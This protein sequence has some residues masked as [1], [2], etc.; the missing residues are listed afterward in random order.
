MI[1]MLF[2]LLALS[3]GGDQKDQPDAVQCIVDNIRDLEDARDPK[4]HATAT[5]LINFMY[6]TPLT[7]TARFR[8]NELQKDFIRTIWRKAGK[9]PVNAAALA[10]PIAAALRFKETGDGGTKITLADG[11]SVT[12]TE[13]DRRQY[14]SVAYGLRAQL[15][16]QQEAMLSAEGPLPVLTRDGSDALKEAVD[17]HTLTT[18]FLADQEARTKS[19][20]EV[21]EDLFQKS[22]QRV[23]QP[24]ETVKPV[25]VTARVNAAEAGYPVLSRIIEQKI[26]SYREYNKI[27]DMLFWSNIS[28]FFARHALPEDEAGRT[29]LRQNFRGAAGYFGAFLLRESGRIAQKDGSPII[30][31]R[32]VNE[33]LQKLTPFKVDDY[34]DITYFYH[35]PPKERY[36]L[37][38]Y[39]TDAFRDSGLHWIVL[40]DA[41]KNPQIRVPVEPDPFAAELIV[42]GIAQF[43]VLVFRIAGQMSKNADAETV[44][45]H[46]IRAAVNLIRQLGAKHASTPAPNEQTQTLV[47]TTTATPTGEEPFFTDITAAS[48]LSFVHRS[49]DWLRRYMRSYLYSVENK[50]EQEDISLD[51]PPS[52]SGSGVAAEDIDGDGLPDILLLS[53]LGDRLYKNLG[54]GRFQDITEQAGLVWS[55]PDGSRGEPRQ[56]IIADLDNDGLRDILI[57][58]VDD[59]HRLYKNMGGN[60]FK[61]VTKTAG[62]GGKGMVAGPATVFDYDRDGLPD[63]YIG[64]YGNYLEGVGPS[65]VRNNYNG[66][67]NRLFRNKGNLQFE[68]KTEGSGLD[69]KGWT[70]AV[71]HTDIDGDGLQDLIVGND[72]GINAYY[73]N[74]GDG[75]FVDIAESL[76]TNLPS[77]S[78]NVGLADLNRDSYPDVYISNIVTM[79]KDESYRLPTRETRM[80]FNPENMATMRILEA[81]HLFVSKRENNKLAGY[82]IS[83]A[84]T[85]GLI[86]TGWAWDADFL[87]FDN[88]GD[89]DLYCVNGLNEYRFYT[90]SVEME[91]QDGGKQTFMWMVRN[92]ESNVFFVNEG[93]KLENRSTESGADLLGNSRSAAYLDIEGDGDLDMILN[94]YHGPAVLYRNNAERYKRNWL[95]LQLDGDPAKGSNRDAIGARI[96]ITPKGGPV[97]WR[98]ISGSIGYLSQHPKE[99]HAGLA[100]ATE[101]DVTIIWPNGDTTEHK[102][103]AAGKTWR[104]EQ[105][106]SVKLAAN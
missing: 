13:R 11:S 23:A 104:I 18:L 56:P 83:D 51:H 35:L 38:A 74:K 52:F 58:Y 43:G 96:L 7:E 12:I 25:E 95:R 17:L 88:D 1:A 46:H 48:G 5:R 6:G 91:T 21:S 37:E 100:D 29:D 24:L 3:L 90:D 32:H 30:R 92:K 45:G 75:T 39:D 101:A 86:S 22:W 60:K 28:T 8:M 27:S 4:C 15:A 40:Q 84:I 16:V 2:T 80:K 50:R 81:N 47:S 31:E 69:N 33:A 97:V 85:R 9:G 49:S 53:G 71:S 99:V 102:G 42:E 93:G 103:L 73:R 59:P 65:L 20:Y 66:L 105:G 89:D 79:V 72:F 57:T 68:D 34:E 44:Q 70:Q 10:D 87:D 76:G 62:L 19:E 14:G 77:N 55:R 78:M 63:I 61:D 106:G 98:E 41:L 36:V 54:D 26:H 94:N 64:Y 67:P 82:E